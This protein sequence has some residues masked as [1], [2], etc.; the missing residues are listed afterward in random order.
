MMKTFAKCLTALCLLGASTFAAAVPMN[1]GVSFSSIDA[2]LFNWDYNADLF[3]FAENNAGVDSVSGDFADALAVGDAANFHDF[4][5][6]SNF[7]PGTIWES[8]DL[9]FVLEQ[10]DT[11]EEIDAYGDAAPEIAVIG[12]EGTL[13]DGIDS[14][15]G[16]W[17][18]SVNTAGGTFSWSSS[19]EVDESANVPE[20]ASLGLIALAA[21]GFAAR[22]KFK[23]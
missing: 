10:I 8:G 7:V 6:N 19:T 13:T 3:D 1:G 14:V 16:Y 9:T 12:G 23:A 15:T 5:Y 18:I 4:Y 20:P 22:R 21:A 17:N 2:S 11:A